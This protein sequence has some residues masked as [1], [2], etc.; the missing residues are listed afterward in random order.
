VSG[1]LQ[2]ALDKIAQEKELLAQL[3]RPLVREDD[4]RSPFSWLDPDDA[5]LMPGLDRLRSDR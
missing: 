3:L 1:E 5:V 2:A 4:R